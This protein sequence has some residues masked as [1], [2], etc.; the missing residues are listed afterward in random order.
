[1]QLKLLLY[2]ARPQHRL[3][4]PVLQ[5]DRARPEAHVPERPAR[6]RGEIH[7]LTQECPQHVPEAKSDHWLLPGHE[8]HRRQFAE[9]FERGGELLDIHTDRGEH[10]AD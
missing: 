10:A 2:P 3:P 7:R 9:A 8:F 4:E 5:P 1:M 6:R